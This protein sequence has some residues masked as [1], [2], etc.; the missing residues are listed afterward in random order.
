MGK[1][2]KHRGGHG[3]E[4]KREDRGRDKEF[5]QKTFGGS[6]HKFSRTIGGA[7]GQ[8]ERHDDAC[9]SAFKVL[10]SI[11]GRLETQEKTL[12]ASEPNFGPYLETKRKMLELEKG[13]LKNPAF[14]DH[15]KTRKELRVAASV[16]NAEKP[17][18][19]RC[20]FV[21]GVK[22]L[23]S[24]GPKAEVERPFNQLKL[25]VPKIPMEPAPIPPTSDAGQAQA[26]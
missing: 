6:G 26:A 13:L 17:K 12:M 24:I 14:S 10:M 5:V 3:H 7:V 16:L 23:E 18:C 1:G 25:E 19:K 4:R 2:N 15:L 20:S 11:R 9:S 22:P 21:A 8:D